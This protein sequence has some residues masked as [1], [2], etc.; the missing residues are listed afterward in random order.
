[1]AVDQPMVPV[2]TVK[3]TQSFDANNR[4]ISYSGLLLTAC[5]YLCNQQ[6]ATYND[7]SGIDGSAVNGQAPG[8]AG[9]AGGSGSSSDTS[10]VFSFPD[11]TPRWPGKYRLK[12][13]VYLNDSTGMQNI[14]HTYSGVFEVQR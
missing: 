2:V 1:M 11:L 10:I 7:F 3:K 6:G 13:I 14:G 5:I 12:A 9:E 4:P 8:E